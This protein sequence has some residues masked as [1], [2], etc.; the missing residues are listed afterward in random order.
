MPA[1]PQ[2]T[3]ANLDNPVEIVLSRTFAARRELVWQAWTD[4]KHVGRWWGPAGFSTTTHAMDFRP[5]GSWRYTMHGPDGRDYP[6]RIDFIEIV[7]PSRLIYKLGGDDGGEPVRFL[8]EVFFEPTGDN[9]GQTRVTMRSIFPSAQERDFVITRVN[10]VEG[11]KQ[12]LANL[13]DYL[14]TMSAG[15]GHEPAFLIS[16]VFA[17]TRERVWEAWTEREHLMRWFGPKG[18][19]LSHATLEL[20]LGGSFHYCM[21]HPNGMEMWGRWVFREIDPANKLVFVSSFSNARGEMAPA[22]FPGLENFP[23]EIL[24]TVT[25]VEHAGISKGTLVTVE[26]EPLNATKAQRDF[27]AAFH[28]SMRQGWTGTM[29]QLADFID[30]KRDMGLLAS[31]MLERH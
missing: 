5:G 27:F 28:G 12:H 23:L 31:Y 16:H 19:S 24:T 21:N 15:A 9:E 17:A 4:P 25:L 6:S 7:K 22:P 3:Q 13:D 2:M 1:E 14:R 20:R 18:A 29:E 30:G 8:T 10:A 26:A 11:G